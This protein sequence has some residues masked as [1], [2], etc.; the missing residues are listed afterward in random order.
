MSGAQALKLLKE[1]IK[2]KQIKKQDLFSI[3]L[4]IFNPIVAIHDLIIGYNSIMIQNYT[5]A[6]VDFGFVILLVYVWFRLYYSYFELL[7]SRI[8]HASW[9]ADFKERNGGQK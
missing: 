8:E 5:H 4:L 1:A 6:I 7:K 3:I 2:T 9:L